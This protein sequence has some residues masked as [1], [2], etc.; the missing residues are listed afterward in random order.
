ML[1]HYFRFF[2]TDSRSALEKE[3]EKLAVAK[4]LGSAGK[5]DKE[6]LSTSGKKPVR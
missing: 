6:Q 3:L 5:K 4:C 1:G 2:F